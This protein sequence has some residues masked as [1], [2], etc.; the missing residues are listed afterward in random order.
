MLRNKAILIF[1][2]ALFF[3]NKGHKLSVLSNKIKSYYIIFQ[4]MKEINW[5]MFLIVNLIDKVY[6]K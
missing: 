1:S 5:M 2:I 6:Q 3:F 4:V